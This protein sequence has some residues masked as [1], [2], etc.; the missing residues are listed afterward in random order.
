MHNRAGERVESR[1]ISVADGL[2]LVPL[3]LVIVA[4]SVYPQVALKRSQR[5]TQATIAPAAAALDARGG[6]VAEATP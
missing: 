6:G 1:E 5:S 3:V 4:L 2:V